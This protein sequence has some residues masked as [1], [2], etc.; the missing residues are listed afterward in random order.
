MYLFVTDECSDEGSDPDP[1]R[2]QRLNL[3]GPGDEFIRV[4]PVRQQIRRL[5]VVHADVVVLE[6][7]GK[8]VIDLPRHIE[9]V[10]DPEQKRTFFFL[11]EFALTSGAEC[12]RGGRCV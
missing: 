10:L 11:R 9:D 2:E 7:T 8:E 6:Q 3:L 5:F 12:V 4:V 1:C